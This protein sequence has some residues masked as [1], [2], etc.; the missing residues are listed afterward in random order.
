MHAHPNI[1]STNSRSWQNFWEFPRIL[2]TSLLS[3]WDPVK[4]SYLDHLWSDSCTYIILTGFNKVN[5]QN[6][7]WVR[8]IKD[9][10]YFSHL[11]WCKWSLVIGFVT[12]CMCV[13]GCWRMATARAEGMRWSHEVMQQRSI[14]L[15]ADKTTV[16]LCSVRFEWPVRPS[17][18]LS[19]KAFPNWHFHYVMV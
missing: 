12:E 13:W 18:P 16:C 6:R 10:K 7:S 2:K 17:Y 15:P 14:K 11:H 5:I 3:L 19:T 8:S 9:D 1:N 4:N